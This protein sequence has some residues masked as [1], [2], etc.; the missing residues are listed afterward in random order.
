[1]QDSTKIFLYE[2]SELKKEIYK[3][4]EKEVK[5]LL[6]YICD[7][8]IETIGEKYRTVVE[9]EKNNIEPLII[10]EHLTSYKTRLS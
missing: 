6:D 3:E 2:N 7:K 1:M 10:F 8:I 4:F 9:N 5:N